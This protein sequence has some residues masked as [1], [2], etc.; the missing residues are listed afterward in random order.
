[1]SVIRFLMDKY[2]VLVKRMGLVPAKPGQIESVRL[3][4]GLGYIVAME[5]QFSQTVDSV[6]SD[7][8]TLDCPPQLSL[9][10]PPPELAVMSPSLIFVEV[11]FPSQS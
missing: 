11:R 2:D 6:L 4:C 7:I 8:Q 10:L 9:C 3:Y 5:V 1:M